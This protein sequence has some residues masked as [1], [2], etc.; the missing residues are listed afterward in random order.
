MLGLGCLNFY[1]TL[2]MVAASTVE[3]DKHFLKGLG[4]FAKASVV[5]RDCDGWTEV[6]MVSIL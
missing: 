5:T 6:R 1:P 3:E 4:A 2:V